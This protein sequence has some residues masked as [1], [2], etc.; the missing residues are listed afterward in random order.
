MI[1]D[2]AGIGQDVKIFPFSQVLQG[3]KIGNFTTIGHN[4]FIGENVVIG[5]N[6][7][8]QG[9][10]YIPEGVEIGDYVFIG[11]GVIFTNVK[12]PQIMGESEYEKIKVCD[13]VRIGAGAIILPGIT[14]YAECFIAAGS[15]VTKDVLYQQ[16]VAGNPAKVKKD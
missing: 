11:P 7:R 16:L 6:C 5:N 2:D 14:L 1:Y 4:V 15:V 13:R 8:I 10:V 3:A 12:Y 9:N